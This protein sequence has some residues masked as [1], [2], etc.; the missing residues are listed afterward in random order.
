ML[1][2]L[3]HGGQVT[4]DE[5]AFIGLGAVL[6]LGLLALAVRRGAHSKESSSGE[7]PSGHS[8][9]SPEGDANRDATRPG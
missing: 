2:V 7:A 9:D 6:L 1:A 8:P 5:L 4:G 3:A